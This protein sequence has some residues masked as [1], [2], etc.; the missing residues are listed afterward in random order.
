MYENELK[1]RF[2]PSG[3]GKRKGLSTGD[4]ETFKRNPFGN[5]GREVIQNSIDARTSDE[6]P[7]TVEFSLFKIS[8]EEIPDLDGLKAAINRCMD[9][10]KS[11]QPLYYN[12]YSK[13]L[14]ILNSKNIE[15]L[16]ISDSNTSGLTGIDRSEDG[17]NNKFLAL[18]KSSGV[19]DK[20]SDTAGGSK[21]VGKNAAFLLSRIKTVFYSTFTEDGAKGYFG[22]ADFISGFVLDDV[23]NEHRDYTQGDGYFGKNNFNAPPEGL[24]N[25][26]RSYKN[27]E[28][29][30][31]TDIYIL[32]LNKEDSWS[33][34]ILNSVLESFMASI[35]KKQLVVKIQNICLD[36]DHVLDIIN[37]NMYVSPKKRAYYLSQYNILRGIGNVQAF[38]IDTEYGTAYLKIL[39]LDE[40]TKWMATHKCVMI[41]YP[42]M[43][44]FDISLPKHLNASAVCIIE[45]GELGKRLR[46]I[47]NPQ[48]NAW[49]PKRIAQPDRDKINYTVESIK[50][51]IENAVLHCF[52]TSVQ[53]IIDP[54]GAGEYL[55]ETEGNGDIGGDKSSSK[56]NEKEVVE[57]SEFK[58]AVNIE[59]NANAKRNDGA[60]VQPDIGESEDD[61]DDVLH[62]TGHN[63]GS[64]GGYSAGE[65]IGGSKPGDNIIMKK[66]QIAGI[67]YRF[68]VLDKTDG[69][70][71]I[72]FISPVTNDKCYLTLYMLGDEL[73]QKTQLRIISLKCNG[74]EM[75]SDSD[76]ECGPFSMKDGEKIELE[77]KTNQTDY[78]ASEV[79]LYASK[80]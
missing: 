49:E 54:Y 25:L 61:G 71:K 32:G 51:Q 38:D 17:K 42:Y 45:R 20:N 33:S 65:E 76:L 60:G 41:R 28:I 67:R 8:P 21:G 9:F 79:K 40:T 48:H 14:K 27:R 18:T 44:I 52:K 35:V 19:S 15:C 64:G 26:D 37:N 57:I 34:E 4:S 78:F 75:E 70:Y 39:V 22:V 47:E 31:G 5:F 12:E 53:E 68:I 73:S 16:R 13:M 58:P 10:W 11:S 66:A 62:P 7:V 3:F 56:M 46:E 69:R 74:K 23:D 80:E 59:R 29:N 77:L 50:E 72:T 43:K 2:A 55:S 63:S 36:G 24:L 6:E 1:W 30:K